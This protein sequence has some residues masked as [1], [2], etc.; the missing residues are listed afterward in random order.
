MVRHGG[1]SPLS[2]RRRPSPPSSA[3]SRTAACSPPPARCDAGDSN[4]AGQLGDGTTT[5]RSTPTRVLGL[6]STA[7]AIAAGST[8]TCAL[9]SGGGVMCWGDNVAGQLGD[10]THTPRPTAAFVDGLVSGAIA[11]T[12]GGYHTC[13]LVTG[14]GVKCWGYRRL[15]TTWR[16][17]DNLPHNS[18][19]R[20]RAP[21]R[22]DHDLDRAVPFVRAAGDR[23]R[24]VLGIERAR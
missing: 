20:R 17:D 9:T 3:V 13:A 10:G 24:E 14:G 23:G 19:R 15:W 16:R 12:A 4:T 21:E 22:C 1:G 5:N 7:S 8:H 2:R 6:L 18:D 11:V